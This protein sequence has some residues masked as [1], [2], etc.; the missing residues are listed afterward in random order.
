MTGE[1]PRAA[2]RSWWLEEALTDPD[3]GG[4][5]APA[6]DRDTTAD[7][8]VVGGG[9]TGLWTA[10]FLKE[11]EPDLDVILLEQD[12][13]GGGPSGRN[14]GFVNAFYDETELLVDRWGDSGART[15]A[16]AA[17]S[18]DEIGA[19]CTQQYV[20]AWFTR[21]GN[22]AV[23]TSAAQDAAVEEALDTAARYGFDDAYRP[24]DAGEV[25]ERFDSPVARRGIDVTHAATVQPARLARGIRRALLERG[26]RIHERTPVRRFA[27]RPNVAADTPGGVVR[28]G[29]A[30]LGLN[31]WAVGWRRF[32]RTI[33]VRGTYIVMTAPAPDRLERLRWTGG[34]GVYDFLTAVHYL[35]TTPD[36]RIAFGG[37]GIR[38]APQRI[39]SRYRYDDR[40][41][42]GLVEDFR[43]WFPTFRDI[44]L[45]AAWGGPV[46][47]SGWHLPFFGTLPGGRAHYGLGFTGNGVG[48]CHLAGKILAGLALD[49]ED[50]ATTLPLVDVE[51]KR[52]PPEPLFTPG[53]RLVSH[54]ILRKER[55]EQAGRRPDPLTNTLAHLPRRLGYNLGP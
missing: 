20:D 25:R 30:I 45:E 47:V 40:S 31:A 22:L 42:A 15:A 26:V 28:A 8:V 6:L 12:I 24:L 55:L 39:T 46:D 53:E 17:R 38:V 1:L 33:M 52:F 18:I 19:W 54:A 51:P 23:S 34:E 44:P 32:R 35:R 11:R 3:L 16:L 27:A 36:G 10:W 29:R 7:V 13:C 37:A 49:A 2:D 5:P 21:S 4:E 48:P 9:Y 41:V 43:R 50:E 14:G